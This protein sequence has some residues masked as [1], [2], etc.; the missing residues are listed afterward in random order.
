MS[1]R[2]TVLGIDTSTFWLNLALVDGEGAVLAEHHELV[3]THT[4]RLV[5]ALEGLLRGAG[6][7][8]EALAAVGAVVGPGSFTGLRVGLASAEGLCQALDIPAYATDSLSALALCAPGAGEGVALLDA[9]RSQVYE[10]RFAREPGGQVRRLSEIRSVSP[11]EVL[12]GPAPAWAI[13]DGVPQVPDWPRNCRLDPLIPNLAVP[14]AREAIGRLQ[15]GEAG[16]RLA[17]LY[18]RPPDVRPPRF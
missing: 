16:E 1:H 2:R 12:A 13:G 18:V 8:R 6:V 9:R 14:A 11:V 4:T 3:K 5:G 17:P 10:A 15:R 7:E